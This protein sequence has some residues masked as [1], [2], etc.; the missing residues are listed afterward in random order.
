MDA[1][2]LADFVSIGDFTDNGDGTYT[3]SG[4]ELPGQTVAVQVFDCNG[5]SCCATQNAD[6]TG[7]TSWESTTPEIIAAMPFIFVAQA[8]DSTA[9]Y[10]YPSPGPT[11]D[12][13]RKTKPAKK[14][15]KKSVKKK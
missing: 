4:I 10:T 6:A 13:K 9:T 5:N 15:P 11:P 8:G 1:V 7:P 3:L 14:P 2:D 12:K